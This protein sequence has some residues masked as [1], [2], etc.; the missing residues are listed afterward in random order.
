MLCDRLCDILT[1]YYYYYYRR[2][3]NH[4]HGPIHRRGL[5]CIRLCGQSVKPYLAVTDRKHQGRLAVE[6]EAKRIANVKAAE[7]AEEA[8]RVADVKA[9][10]ETEAK[11]L[12]VETEAR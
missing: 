9:A 11:R 2:A 8:K 5:D 12:A 1:Y 3:I 7:D 4:A 6:T 10:D